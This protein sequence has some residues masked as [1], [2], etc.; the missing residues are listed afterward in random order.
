LNN[1]AA[2][3]GV[4]ENTLAL[5]T[6]ITSTRARLVLATMLG[7]LL[8]AI[9]AAVLTYGFLSARLTPLATAPAPLHHAIGLVAAGFAILL[10]MCVGIAAAIAYRIL[11]RPVQHLTKVFAAYTSGQTQLRADRSI[12]DELNG[13]RAGFNAIADAYERS[14]LD[15]RQRDAHYHS[16]VN[17]VREVIFQLSA[18]CRWLFLSHP[19]QTLTDYTEIDSLG[20]TLYEF[21]A[22]ED[23]DQLRLRIEALITGD[24][25]TCHVEFRLLTR[26]GERVWVEMIAQEAI[27]GDGEK[28]YSGTL[29][30]VS[31]RHYQQEVVAL[32]RQAE[33]FIN[34]DVQTEQLL[35]FFC[36]R[37]SS[38]FGAKLVIAATNRDQRVSIVG[39]SDFEADFLRTIGSVRNSNPELGLYRQVFAEQRTVSWFGAQTQDNWSK[40]AARAGIGSVTAVPILVKDDLQ[41][42]LALHSRAGSSSLQE[43]G[44]RFEAVCDRI[45]EVLRRAEGLRWLRLQRTAMESVANGIMIV[46]ID[47]EI[48]WV[49]PA[50]ES[51]SGYARSEL[52]G[53]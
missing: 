26:S 27:D 51:L 1:E 34:E 5:S 44:Q 18:Q 42:L 17:S 2:A 29:D 46:N 37:L 20:R 21:V 19:W 41:V 36:E 3:G 13:L 9:P 48:I 28:V 8:V 25:D 4:G 47:H 7:A 10:L 52:V 45:A 15:L 32:L 50:I 30:D 12:D 11:V 38:L 49:N 31:D 33:D 24:I 16:V 14:Q 22:V 23:V 35:Q 53:R 6:L 39:R 40:A 43:R